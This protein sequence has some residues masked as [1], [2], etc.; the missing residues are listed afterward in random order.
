MNKIQCE[1]CGSLDIIKTDDNFFRCSAC[2]CNYTLEQAR[3]L[4]GGKFTTVQP[5]FRIRAGRLEEYNGESTAADLPLTV[6]I[7]GNEVFSDCPGLQSVSI[8][9]SCYDIGMNAFAGCT[10]L[11]SITV[12]DS[13]RSIGYGAFRNCTGLES[14]DISENLTEIS[15]HLFENCE[16]LN[17]TE[18]PD[19]L[20]K[21]GAYA[22]NGCK[23]LQSIIIPEGVKEIGS[24][25]FNNCKALKSIFIPESVSSVGENT[26]R[27]CES[28][29]EIIC[30][31]E[32]ALPYFVSQFSPRV[33][34]NHFMEKGLCRHCGG[35][36]RGLFRKHCSV[37]LKDKDYKIKKGKIITA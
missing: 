34:I 6:T 28:I 2:G 37:C 12:P 36:F 9:D 10:G 22:F 17:K 35:T 19:K 13:V 29:E 7:I 33:D 8:P 23:A 3:F 20:T 5:D 1:L 26:F 15:G 14:I 21:I 27:G 31:S 25:A 24:Y 32:S 16:K 11:K 4:I 30:L 18:L